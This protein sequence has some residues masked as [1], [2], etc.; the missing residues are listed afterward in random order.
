MALA[1]GNGDAVLDLVPEAQ[2]VPVE[3][4]GHADRGIGEA[5]EFLHGELAAG[6]TAEESA[7]ALGA[8]IDS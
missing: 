6:E 2:G 3:G 5:V 1:G 7:S 8:E 4:A